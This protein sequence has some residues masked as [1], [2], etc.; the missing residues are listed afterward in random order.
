MCEPCGR[1]MC[2]LHYETIKIHTWCLLDLVSLCKWDE[3][4]RVELSR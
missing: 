3:L 1:Q 2:A 4:L